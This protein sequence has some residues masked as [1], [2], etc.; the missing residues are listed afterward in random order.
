MATMLKSDTDV[1]SFLKEQH[2][3]IKVLF[4]SVKATS[5]KERAT[6]FYALRRLL[7]VHE[8]VEEEIVH[9]AARRA[10]SDGDTIVA[11]RL[12]EEQIAKDVLTSLEKQDVDSAE[13]E[14][15]FLDLEK[16]VIDHAEAEEHQE[17]ERLKSAL[18]QHQLVRMRRAAEIAEAVAPTRPHSGIESAAANL[19]T[20]P[21]ASMV[22]RT[23]DA[24]A[25]KA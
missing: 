13:F 5:G 8:T 14:R 20:G 25:G 6:Q 9:P 1:V 10:L 15:T 22:D 18:D 21:F 16:A 24:L 19:I 17:F 23:R 11:A 4:M 3:Q 2:E 7:A 12:R